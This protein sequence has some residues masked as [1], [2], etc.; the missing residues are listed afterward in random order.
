MYMYSL[1]SVSA[2]A[3]FS[4]K[5]LRCEINIIVNQYSYHC[6]IMGSKNKTSFD[7][8]NISEC[9]LLSSSYGNE[10]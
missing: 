3:T 4:V 6:F 1:V 10:S 9:H 7:E 2:E 5:Q 8:S